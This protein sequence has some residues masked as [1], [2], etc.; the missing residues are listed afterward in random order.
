MGPGYCPCWVFPFPLEDMLLFAGTLRG[1]EMDWRPLP[2][3][4]SAMKDPRLV[5]GGDWVV[6]VG[7]S[8]IAVAGERIAAD[9][10]GVGLMERRANGGSAGGEDVIQLG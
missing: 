10:N 4:M 9:R 2:P 6:E 7:S 5:R 8:A 3:N 1:A